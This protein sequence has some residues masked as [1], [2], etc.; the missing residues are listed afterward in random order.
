MVH[1]TSL[2]TEHYAMVSHMIN[3]TEPK[4]YEEASQDPAY[5]QAMDKEIDALLTNQ[6]WEYIDLPPGKRAISSKWAY[7]VKLKSDGTLERLKLRLTIR[8]FTQQYSVDY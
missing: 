4:S 7:K 2:P 1:S 6:T 3:Y 8:G 5:L